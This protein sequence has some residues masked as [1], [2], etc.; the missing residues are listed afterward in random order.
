MS[1][2]GTGCG[3]REGLRKGTAGTDRFEGREERIWTTANG[4]KDGWVWV[5]PT[6]G[7]ASAGGSI[8]TVPGGGVENT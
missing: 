5:V 8:G 7:E 4:I 1:G 2:R 6:G 3:C